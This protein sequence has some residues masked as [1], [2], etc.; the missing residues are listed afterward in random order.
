MN[1][2]LFEA[3]EVSVGDGIA[4]GTGRLG[5]GDPR[6]LH[7]KKVLRKKAGDGFAAGVV[8][9]PEGTA[10]VLALDE[11]GLSFEFRAER[12]MRPLFPVRLAVGFPRPIQL[13]RLLRDAA[14][15]GV[16]RVYLIG[17]ELG[18][19]SY[20]DS[21]LVDRG[22]A[23]ESLLEGVSQARGTALPSLDLYDSAREFVETTA[24]EDAERVLLDTADPESS[25]FSMDLGTPTPRRP[26]VLAIG[27][28][29]GWSAAERALFREG[30]Y[31]VASLGPRILRTETATVAA[32]SIALAKIGR[33]EG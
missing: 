25:L 15:L 5:R 13:K 9:G 8:D 11:G 23:R 32:L 27:S 29:R 31:R 30:G 18:E 19:R 12:P 17:T 14:S 6:Y 2:V 33:M 7:I 21:S 26:L 28:E 20:R 10:R 16:E 22:A 3:A 1:I 24:D 4:T